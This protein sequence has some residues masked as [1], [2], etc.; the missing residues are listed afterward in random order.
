MV[1]IETVLARR[2]PFLQ[3]LRRRSSGR[4]QPVDSGFE[5]LLATFSDNWPVR[6][7][8]GPI[9]VDPMCDSASLLIRLDG[10]LESQ[11]RSR[12]LRFRD[13]KLSGL[14]G[15]QL[16]LECARPRWLGSTRRAGLER[17]VDPRP[18]D[19]LAGPLR[20]MLDI[21]V[22]APDRL[23]IRIRIGAVFEET[24]HANTVQPPTRPGPSRR[25]ARGGELR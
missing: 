8:Q 7:C 19:T 5:A 4:S 23:R 17:A 3:S 15:H 14:D 25:P 21:G 11:P 22:A 1:C 24:R 9:D 2:E 10:M 13:E 18:L 12:Q 6:E 16:E 20:P